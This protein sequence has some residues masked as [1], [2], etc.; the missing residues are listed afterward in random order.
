MKISEHLCIDVFAISNK[1][2]DDEFASGVKTGN[3]SRFSHRFG[4]KPQK[5]LK[6]GL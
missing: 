6:I 3:G 1:V 2:E 5:W 4:E